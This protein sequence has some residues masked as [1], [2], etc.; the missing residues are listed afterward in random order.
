MSANGNEMSAIGDRP[1]RIKLVADSLASRSQRYSAR[2]RELLNRLG[3]QAP[4]RQHHWPASANNR[5]RSIVQL[6]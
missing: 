1:L 6:I 2:D 5:G 4:H 3:S